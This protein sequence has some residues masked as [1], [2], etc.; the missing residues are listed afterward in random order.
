MQ[1]AVQSKTMDFSIQS[2]LICVFFNTLQLC[3][4]QLTWSELGASSS[5]TP[6][7]RSRPA[8]AFDEDNNM[9]LVF[10]G[11]SS[12]GILEDTWTF[13]LTS[14]IWSEISTSNTPG[15]RFDAIA[16]CFKNQF[17]ISTGEGDNKVFYDDIWSLDY[18]SGNGTSWIRLDQDSSKKPDERYGSAGGL[19][20]TN[21]ANDENY[22]KFY[23]SHGFSSVR[24]SDTFVFDLN[25][26]DGGW[27]Q[28]FDGT[29][30]YSPDLPHPRCLVAT[31][32]NSEGFTMFGGCLASGG[33]GGPCPALDG[34]YYEATGK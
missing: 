18:L 31:T 33:A 11:K 7:G 20:T 14:E 17:I 8:L 28:V 23:I 2:L 34:W 3:L 13:N 10:G 4:S 19:I 16:G 27:K 12:D 24:Y 32:S 22:G 9:L 25:N 6:S 30:P 26:T 15:E 29:T 21:D 5:A 1:A